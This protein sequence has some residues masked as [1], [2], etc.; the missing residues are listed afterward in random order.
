MD[1]RSGCQHDRSRLHNTRRQEFQ[2]RN[3]SI[4]NVCDDFGKP[5]IADHV[6]LVGRGVVDE[7]EIHRVFVLLRRHLT[8]EAR[9]PPLGRIHQWKESDKR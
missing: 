4:A 1:S 7:F 5:K 6:C 8:L 3:G 2:K 9:H